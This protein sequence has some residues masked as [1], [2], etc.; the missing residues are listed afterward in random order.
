MRGT[1]GHPSR[2]LSYVDPHKNAIVGLAKPSLSQ[3]GAPRGNSAGV[4][5][6]S[7]VEPFVGRGTTGHPSRLLSYVT[8]HKNVILSLA[9]PSLS[10]GGVPRG[11]SAGAIALFDS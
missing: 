5:A 1:A 8:L 3:G 6:V 2:L 7:E 10:Q 9:K 11:N 4:I